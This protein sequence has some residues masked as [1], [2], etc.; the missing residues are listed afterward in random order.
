M[1]ISNR[2]DRGMSR[3]IKF[4]AWNGVKMDYDWFKVTDRQSTTVG[5]IS[6]P[7]YKSPSVMNSCPLEVMQY[8]GLK[9]K[10]GVEIYE[11]DIVA[12]YEADDGFVFSVVEWTDESAS[13]MLSMWD[14]SMEELGSATVVGNIYENHD[15]INHH[16]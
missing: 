9:D 10:N 1:V 8:T 13:F 5:D 16:Q 4:R 3:E 12:D 7:P 6:L 14:E 2:G 15:L 11:G